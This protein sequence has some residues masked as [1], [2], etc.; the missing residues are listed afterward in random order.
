MTEHEYAMREAM[1]IAASDEH[2]A[3]RPQI[4]TAD[5]RRVFEAGFRTAWQ[6]QMPEVCLPRRPEPEAPANTVG[7]EWDAYSGIQML[8]FGRAC[9]EAQRLVTPNAGNERTAD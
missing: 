2:F 7:L 5:R 1:Q 3:A 6:V 4:D 8:C 9:A